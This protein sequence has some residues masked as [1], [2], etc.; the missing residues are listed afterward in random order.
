MQFFDLV[1]ISC[2]FL[3]LFYFCYHLLKSPPAVQCRWSPSVYLF[4]MSHPALNER[5]RGVVHQD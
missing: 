2:G 4:L 5:E 1:L 3:C